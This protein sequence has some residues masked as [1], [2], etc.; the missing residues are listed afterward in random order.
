MVAARL[1]VFDSKLTRNA[2]SRRSVGLSRVKVNFAALPTL[3]AESEARRFDF[4][5]F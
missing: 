5:K 3:R 2:A 4:F 1:P